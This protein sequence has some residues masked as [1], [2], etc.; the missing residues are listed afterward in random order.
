MGSLRTLAKRKS[1]LRLFFIME[2]T[3]IVGFDG[4]GISK[5]GIVFSYKSGRTLSICLEK[6]GYLRVFLSKDNVSKKYAVHRLVATTFLGEP[7]GEN[8]IVNHKNGI[9]TDN[10]VENLEWCSVRDNVA[11]YQLYLK[12]FGKFTKDNQ[13]DAI[14]LS[15]DYVP[16]R[17][18]QA[19]FYKL[20]SKDQYGII[21]DLCEK[22]IPV[23]FICRKFPEVN[24]QHI[25]NVY[26]FINGKRVHY[27]EV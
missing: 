21:Y 3:N 2:F 8:V 27:K 25:K 24:E 9:K 18:N 16:L 17:E 22:K 23:R 26:N 6:H 20:L 13:M 10:R 12:R 19:G 4:Y 7:I 1:Q 11:H 15:K 5:E 14:G